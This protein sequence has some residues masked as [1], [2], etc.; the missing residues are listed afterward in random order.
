[1]TIL[2]TRRA[3]LL[4][5]T[6]STYGTQAS[7]TPATDAILVESPDFMPDITVLTRDF[8]RPSLSPIPHQVGRVLGK[9]SFTTELRGNGTE[10]AGSLTNVPRI[11]RLFQACGYSLTAMAA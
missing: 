6:E 11:A 5:T 2:L 10:Q 1:M 4:A 9:M 3:V 8:A 7:Q